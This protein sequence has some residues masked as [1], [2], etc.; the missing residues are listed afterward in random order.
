MKDHAENSHLTKVDAF[1]VNRDQ[2]IGL[3]TW[4]KIHPNVSNDET[5]SP[6]TIQALKN[7]YQFCDNWE[8]PSFNYHLKEA[9]IE[10][11]FVYPFLRVSQKS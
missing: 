4:F 7:F 6:K 2:V 8:I 1:R 3:E 11:T 9:E 10:I 5:A